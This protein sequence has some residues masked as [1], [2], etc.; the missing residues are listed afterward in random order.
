[1]LRFEKKTY[2]WFKQTGEVPLLNAAVVTQQGFL[3]YHYTFCTFFI[4]KIY[5]SYNNFKIV[6]KNKWD[7]SPCLGREKLEKFSDL[8]KVSY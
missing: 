4:P 6:H 7:C 2:I 3:H 5:M 1:M 8:V